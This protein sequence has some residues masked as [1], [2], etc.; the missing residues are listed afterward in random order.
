MGLKLTL[1]YSDII[2]NLACVM[3]VTFILIFH[4]NAAVLLYVKKEISKITFSYITIIRF[5][6]SINEVFSSP[7]FNP[8][9]YF[10]K[11]Q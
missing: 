4:E 3:H 1:N 2:Y 7:D 6:T 8:Y 5:N 11:E 9:Y 10:S